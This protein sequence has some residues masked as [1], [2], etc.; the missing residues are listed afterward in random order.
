MPMDA[1]DALKAT[2]YL[3]DFVWRSYIEDLSDDELMQRPV[4][5]T[6]HIIWQIG[7]LISS[8]R[9]LV[10]GVCPGSMPP[11]PEGFADRYTKETAA[12]DDPAKFHSREELLRVA[13][14][15]RQGTLAALDKLSA[16]DLD[17]PTPERLQRFGPTVGYIFAMIGGHWQMHAGQWAVLRRKLGRPP[18]F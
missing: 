17:R 10:E 1:K 18:L 15:Q 5:G 3:P 12:S 13:A 11:L 9:G 8:E 16:A 6:N 7:H 2:M 4:A 14:E